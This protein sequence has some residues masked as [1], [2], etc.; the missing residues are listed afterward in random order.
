LDAATVVERMRISRTMEKE[1]P[2]RSSEEKMMSLQRAAEYSFE[3]ANR[4][5]ESLPKEQQAWLKEHKLVLTPYT[6]T[7][8]RRGVRIPLTKDEQKTLEALHTKWYGVFIERLMKRDDL[9]TAT[10]DRLQRILSK[11]TENAREAARDE[12]VMRLPKSRVGSP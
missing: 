11:M 12:M 1:R 4:L 7:I 2:E 5:H 6:G 3:R 9:R 10:P 8:E